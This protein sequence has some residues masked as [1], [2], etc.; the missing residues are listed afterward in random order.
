MMNFIEKLNEVV[1]QLKSTPEIDVILYT[2]LPPDL[3]AITTVEAELGY[4]LDASITDFYKECGGIQL[5]W[6]NKKNELFDK[7]KQ[8]IESFIKP[9]DAFTYFGQN[10]P[11]DGCIMIPDIKTVFLKHPEVDVSEDEFEDYEMLTDWEKLVVQPF[12]MFGHSKDVAF[13]LNNTSNPPMLLGSDNQ[14]CYTDSYVIYFEEYLALLLKTKGARSRSKFL[15]FDSN[16]EIDGVII[17]SEDIENLD[18]IH[19][20]NQIL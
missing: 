20:I 12:D 14:A 4:K 11:P 9:L 7:I 15:D 17:K 3:G 18:E 6:L 1:D 19:Y 2:V 10:M 13:I 8:Q 16:A 5:L